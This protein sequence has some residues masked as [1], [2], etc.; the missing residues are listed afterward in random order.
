MDLDGHLD[1][2]FGRNISFVEITL[3]QQLP[4]SRKFT[5]HFVFADWLLAR[6]HGLCGQIFFRNRYGLVK[7]VRKILR[8]LR[9]LTV[10]G[11][12]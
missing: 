8:V 11:H 6:V 12:R 1:H 4:E 9:L 5:Q 3:F 2:A 10:G 7:R